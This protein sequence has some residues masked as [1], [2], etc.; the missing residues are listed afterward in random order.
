[1]VPEHLGGLPRGIGGIFT[2]HASLS[3]V[4]S[5]PSRGAMGLWGHGPMAVQD[6]VLP[7][8]PWHPKGVGNP[9]VA[10]ENQQPVVIPGARAHGTP[11]L[12]GEIQP[13]E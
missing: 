3:R 1:M 5:P 4:Y 6:H 12:G 10:A 2:P 9:E 8:L 13:R 11:P 7:W